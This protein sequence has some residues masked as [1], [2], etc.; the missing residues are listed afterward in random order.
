MVNWI[1]DPVWLMQYVSAWD[2]GRPVWIDQDHAWKDSGKVTQQD[3]V[4]MPHQHEYG[5]RMRSNY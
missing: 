3:S 5:S 4:A 1:G 2:L